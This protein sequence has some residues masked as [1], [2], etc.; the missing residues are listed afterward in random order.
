ML[1]TQSVSSSV[2]SNLEISI[3]SEK[4]LAGRYGDPLNPWADIITVAEAWCASRPD[5]RMHHLKSYIRT[6]VVREAIHNQKVTKLLTRSVS[7]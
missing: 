2:S 3:E 6:Q 1:L 4:L 7:P 5:V